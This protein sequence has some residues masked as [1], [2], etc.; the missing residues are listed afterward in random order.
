MA[1]V[2]KRTN[3]KAFTVKIKI[4]PFCYPL[5]GCG[6]LWVVV[7][8]CEVVVGGC[9]VV[10]GGCGWLWVFV[11]GFGWLWVIVDHCGWLWVVV[12]V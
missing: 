2:F 8:D 12:G 9:G 6:W 5:C 1:V 3:K 4:Y 10:V 11:N 7:G